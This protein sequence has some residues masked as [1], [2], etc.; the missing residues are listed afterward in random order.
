MKKYYLILAFLCVV[1]TV[2][3]SDNANENSYAKNAE[4]ESK[5]K[6][7]QILLHDPLVLEKAKELKEDDSPIDLSYDGDFHKIIEKADKIVVRDGGY[8]CCGRVVD[9]DV[10]I[11]E[12]RDAQEIKEVYDNIDFK[13]EEYNSDCMCCGYPGIDWY[14]GK[15][16][17]ALTALKH[18]KQL[19]GS[20]YNKLTQKSSKWLCAWLIK[21]GAK[22]EAPY[23]VKKE[24]EDWKSLTVKPVVFDQA[25]LKDCIV[26]LAKCSNVEIELSKKL[27]QKNDIAVDLHL[28]TS[29]EYYLR[30]VLFM[31]IEFIEKKHGVKIKI[32]P[33]SNKNVV[34]D[35]NQPK[36]KK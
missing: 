11:Y 27:K 14:K 23:N 18:G 21:H 26:Y 34:L 22:I 2:F 5:Q 31:M 8:K 10:I 35:L 13:I 30:G 6:G 29:K 24:K 7:N 32:K 28:D 25:L 15:K 1:F 9:S 12:T 20:G 19:K 33:I 16:R 36:D 4:S 17:I 3:G